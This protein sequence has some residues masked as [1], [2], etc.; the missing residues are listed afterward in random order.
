MQ[1]FWDENIKLL[2]AKDPILYQKIMGHIPEDVGD[3]IPTNTVPTLRFHRPGEKYAYA[4]DTGNPLNE[5]QN[6]LPILKNKKKLNETV[7]IFTGMGL[8]YTQLIAL[9][10]RSDI[11][12]LIILEPSLDIFCLA[13]R[14][15]DLSPLLTSRKVSIF[16]GEINWKQFDETINRKTIETDFL[17]SD[18]L[19][20]FDW[21]PEL[22]SDAKNRAR[23]LAVRAISGMGVLNIHGERL[24]RNRLRNLAL[25]RE[26]SFADRLKG[27]FKN[28]PALLI[29][30]G[31]SLDQSIPQLKAAAGRCVMIAVDS[32]LVP[33]LKH[34]ITPDFVVTLDYRELN[35]E[36]LSPDMVSSSDF[37]LV[38]GIT[39][40]V[41]TARRLPLKHLFFCFQNNDTQNWLLNALDIRYLV[42]PVGTVASLALSFAQMIGANP[43]IMVGYDFALTVKDTDHV[44]GVIFNHNWHLRKDAITVKGVDGR[45]VRT[46]D[47]LLEF[48]Q[49]FE[50]NMKLHSRDYINAT[51]AGA[52]IEGARPESL[53]LV[54]KSRLSALQDVDQIVEAALQRKAPLSLSRFAAAARRQIKMAENSL[55]QINSIQETSRKVVKGIEGLKDD[56]AGEI[57]GISQLPVPLQKDKR[58]LNKLYA[59]LKPFMPMEEVAAKKIYQARKVEEIERAENY[60]EIILKESKILDLEMEGH[61]YG[62]RIF[63]ESVSSLLAFLQR[64]DQVLNLKAGKSREIL[65]L[66][67][68]YID[69]MCPVKA[70]SLLEKC[71]ADDSSSAQV[72]LFMGVAQAQMLR[73][74]DAFYSWNMAEENEP[75]CAEAIHEH[76]RRLA[77]YWVKRGQQEPSIIEKCIKRALRLCEARDFWT[78]PDN[79]A[80]RKSVIKINELFKAKNIE[81][82]ESFLIIWRPVKDFIPEWDFLMARA[83]FEKDEREDALS[84]M[85]SALQANPENPEWLAFSARILLETG[86]F[87]KGIERLQK[88]VSQDRS[89]AVLWEELGD[90]LSGMKD[91]ESAVVAY[92]KCFLAL[93]DRIDVLRKYGDCYYNTGQYEAAKAAYQAVL[94]K[95]PANESA[96]I[97]ISKL[98]SV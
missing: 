54:I 75:G 90:T 86:P 15:V 8:G 88:A 72:H 56:G 63:I 98:Q 76:R 37:S 27:V 30:A 10:Q 44:E 1:S 39:S 94:E 65:A 71:V 45:D 70:L 91:Y 26:A 17:F 87:D 9:D 51:A 66:A 31:P 4:Y 53:D 14:H 48:K 95:D 79:K 18:F 13:L 20:L 81:A 16:A 89:Q 47:F 50:Q 2:R 12:R 78:D 19:A 82:A 21:K 97:K 46:L 74:E 11:F 68:L 36:K 5:I 80:W 62:I 49:N 69:E 33:L 96:Q 3:I 64:E 22:Y 41:P 93:P 57:S 60:I 92:E 29:S 83:R 52:H 32:A 67:E 38:A 43:V 23:A 40:S 58:K 24:F 25:L 42:E 84:L 61:E 35:S 7:C 28:I 77:D 34:G 59:K 73:F 55:K 6:R 85:E